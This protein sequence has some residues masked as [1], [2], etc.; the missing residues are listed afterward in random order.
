MLLCGR[1]FGANANP[2][3]QS[4]CVF[5]DPTSEML[6]N[7]PVLHVPCVAATT[8]AACAAT[9]PRTL[10]W[11]SRANV[12]WAR[13]RRLSSRTVLLTHPL[14][15][16]LGALHPHTPTSRG[17]GP[18]FTQPDTEMRY[19]QRKR[20]IKKRHTMI[21]TKKKSDRAGLLVPLRCYTLGKHPA[22]PLT[23]SWQRPCLSAPQSWPY[24]A[25]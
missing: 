5:L 10:P 25:P 3:W 9:A 2:E 20:G 1:P 4:R 12:G 8:Q 19:T 22:L 23:S 13:K 15:P 18:N 6:D 7:A 21:P 11:Q 14:H 17:L 16:P 24:P